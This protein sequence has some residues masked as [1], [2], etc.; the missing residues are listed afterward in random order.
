MVELFRAR[1]EFS[2]E[3]DP[4]EQLIPP[5]WLPTSFVK[6]LTMVQ[7]MT[8]AELPPGQAKAPPPSSAPLLARV[9]L[10][11]V[12]L[13][14]FQMAPPV[15]P[16][17]QP[18]MEQRSRLS[19]ENWPLS[20]TPPPRFPLA[21]PLTRLSLVR[22]IDLLKP[23]I[24]RTRKRSLASIVTPW[25]MGEASILR[26]LSAMTRGELSWITSWSSPLKTAG[27]KMM[28]SPLSASAMAWRRE[29]GPESLELVTSSEV[30]LRRTLS[31]WARPEKV[32]PRPMMRGEPMVWGDCCELK[33][34]EGASLKVPGEELISVRFLFSLGP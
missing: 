32:V 17:L 30:I 23:E 25:P 22:L 6:L 7:L 8:F 3:R 10:I 31:K 33:V 13:P 28:V 21:K 11:R 4:L 5:P 18:M 29:P 34:M 1:M 12:R 20:K 24:S 14:W 2:I 16:A 26:S 19:L 15:V 9:V 27:S